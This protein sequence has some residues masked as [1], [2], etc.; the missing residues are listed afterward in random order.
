MVYHCGDGG[1]DDASICNMLGRCFPDCDT[2]FNHDISTASHTHNICDFSSIGDICAKEYTKDLCMS[3]CSSCQT[4]PDGP[5]CK[6]KMT[7]KD[8]GKLSGCSVNQWHVKALGVT[9]T[10]IELDDVDIKSRL[11]GNA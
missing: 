7:R 2:F 1:N 10:S 5:G 6:S 9:T 11:A 4:I 3:G 8:T